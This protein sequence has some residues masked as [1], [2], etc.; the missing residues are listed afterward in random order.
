MAAAIDELV[1]CGF[2][3]SSLKDPYSLPCLH[4][5]CK[6]CLIS[7]ISS[8]KIT[9][10][11]CSTAHKVDGTVDKTFKPYGLA[12]FFMN[13]KSNTFPSKDDGED[14]TLDG[15]CAECA[16]PASKKKEP[17]DTPP[18]Q[19]KISICHHCSK[20]ICVNCRNKH[21]EAQRK[22]TVGVLENFELGS[23]NLKATNGKNENHIFFIFA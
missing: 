5:F 8:G 12:Q 23:A 17:E 6:Q 19:V 11:T 3:N 4:G 14:T 15:V 7:N 1:K 10:K 13:F 22:E 21:Y 20:V 18:P 2:C 9:C 16:P